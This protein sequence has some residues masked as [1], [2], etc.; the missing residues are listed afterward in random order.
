MSVE[1]SDG[2]SLILEAG[3]LS[4]RLTLPLRV[5]VQGIDAVLISAEA[6]EALSKVANRRVGTLSRVDRDPELKAFIDER[7]AT[8]E[9][10]AIREEAVRFFGAE[11]VPSSS[12]LGRYA[13]ARREAAR[14]VTR[15]SGRRRGPRNSV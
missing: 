14:A 13:F 1:A 4:A 3:N 7:L 8:H 11:R 6:Y 2:P 5:R 12:A 10:S 9:M 15:Q